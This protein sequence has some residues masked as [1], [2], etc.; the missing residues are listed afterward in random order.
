MLHVLHGEP[1]LCTAPLSVCVK[2][3]RA[4]VRCVGT[5]RGSARAV[6]ARV[7]EHVRVR[8]AVEDVHVHVRLHRRARAQGQ[9]PRVGPQALLLEGP[10]PRM[11]R[12]SDHDTA[13]DVPPRDDTANFLNNTHNT[14]IV[15][16][17]ARMVGYSEAS[18]NTFR[19][20]Y[21]TSGVRPRPSTM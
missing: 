20:V 10:P 17:N 11:R 6:D 16:E 1:V 13:R 3:V 5:M 4:R 21:N 19:G 2:R 8:R 9:P 7:R 14:R 15:G 12:D 18:Y